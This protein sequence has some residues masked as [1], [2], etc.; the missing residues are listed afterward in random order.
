MLENLVLTSY[1]ISIT[2]KKI[3]SAVLFPPYLQ[4]TAPGQ[5]LKHAQY[6]KAQID[7]GTT[8]CSTAC[9]RHYNMWIKSL[10]ALQ[11][12]A[13]LALGTTTYDKDH[14]K[15]YNMQHRSL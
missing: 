14:F 10:Q 9:F 6:H 8:T 13:Q 3:P 5:C 4:Y 11:H 7:L 12:T 15:H 1:A 2:C